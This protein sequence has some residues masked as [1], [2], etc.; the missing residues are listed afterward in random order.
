MFWINILKSIVNVLHTDVSPRQVAGGVALGS[1]IGLTPVNA[2]HN[3]LI[4][5][6]ILILQVNI[7]AALLSVGIFKLI[8]FI[9]DPL[10]QLLGYALLVQVK[11]L[12]PLW[13]KLYNMPI[14]PYTH[15]NN[16]VVLGSLIIALILFIPVF[17]GTG[18]LI[19]Y[20]RARWRQKVENM[21]VV[22]LLKMTSFYNL[23]DRL[24]KG[25]S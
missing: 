2:L 1:I 14:V 12:T 24:K 16:T 21:K 15:F 6:L 20:Y 25:A 11:P 22:K 17:V 23:Y 18:R 19:L 9:I 10:A 8:A 3:Y 7:G 13:T 5:F 4:L